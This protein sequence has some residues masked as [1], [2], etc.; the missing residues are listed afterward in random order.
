MLAITAAHDE[1]HQ[2]HLSGA[3]RRSRRLA[4]AAALSSLSRRGSRAGVTA[5]KRGA[6]TRPRSLLVLR[7]DQGRRGRPASRRRRARRPRRVRVRK[8]DLPLGG[9]CVLSRAFVALANCDR[10]SKIGRAAKRCPEPCPELPD[11]DVVPANSED[12]K[13]PQRQAKALQTRDLL[14]KR[15]GVRVPRRALPPRLLLVGV[16][17][18]A[19]EVWGTL[20]ADHFS[21]LRTLGC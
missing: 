12:L 15:F 7:R 5:L 9:A 16:T 10:R 18:S 1:D 6:A 14:I 2:P 11:S 20:F 17:A 8:R 21:P 19:Y 3:L 4:P 13:H